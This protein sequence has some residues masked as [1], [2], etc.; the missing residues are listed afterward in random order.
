MDLSMEKGEHIPGIDL[1][2]AYFP[3]T[4]SEFDVSGRA[5][6]ATE[7][8]QSF[9]PFPALE[10]G[11][12]L[13]FLPCLWSPWS[14]TAPAPTEGDEP[15][16]QGPCSHSD[17]NEV[18]RESLPLTASCK[19]SPSHCV[20]GIQVGKDLE[21]HGARGRRRGCAAAI[22][23]SLTDPSSQ[24]LLLSSCFRVQAPRLAVVWGVH[25]VASCRDC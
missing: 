19:Y 10:V 22:P 17:L 12:F 1:L 25:G 7:S 5:G 18:P 9:P 2:A 20:H 4:Q 24:L 16:P 14:V 3:Q 23:C 11:F 13:L 15:S 21:G 6:G 8:S